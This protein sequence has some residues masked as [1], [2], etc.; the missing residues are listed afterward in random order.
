MLGFYSLKF[1]R[2][3]SSSAIK[4]LFLFC[5]L[6]P[7]T[8]AAMDAIVIAEKAV[9]YSDTEMTS[10]LGYVRRGKKISVGEVPRNKARV[11][12]TIVSGKVAYIRVEDVTT[13]RE[14]MHSERLVAER[15][16]TATHEAYETKYTL[17]YFSYNSIMD[18]NE[19]NAGVMDGASHQWHGISLK[20]EVLLRKKYDLQIIS[21]Y[22]YTSAKAFNAFEL[23]AG[24]GHRLIDREKFLL[25]LEGQLLSIP[26][27]TFSYR[28]DFRI[29]S[30]GYTLGAGLNF[31]YKFENN[32][33]IE[34]FG[35]AYRTSLF[36]F[37]LPK[38]YKG[39][40]PVFFGSRIGVGVN[41]RY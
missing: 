6:C 8:W 7:K 17:A 4:L 27:S 16:K 13:E 15:F 35:G 36:E 10:P 40:S 3:H 37:D 41:Y 18:I 1:Q 32:W 21:N 19:D 28:S 30:Y 23:G 38:P 2:V 25:R 31:L 14:S 39:F 5:F 12:P 9:I 33:G 34:A 29:K 11:Y 24:V 26:F 22:M 20:G